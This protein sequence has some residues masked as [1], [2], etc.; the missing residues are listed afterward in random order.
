MQPIGISDEA[1]RMVQ[2]SFKARKK[3]VGLF[4]G[5]KTSGCTGYSYVLEFIDDLAT[6][7]DK[8]ETII[9]LDKGVTLVSNEKSLVLLNGSILDYKV[10]GLNKGFE[11]INPNVKDQCGCGESFNV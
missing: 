1:A 8:P 2:E 5:V 10:K 7:E 11:F 6:Y 9:I 4:V 3:G